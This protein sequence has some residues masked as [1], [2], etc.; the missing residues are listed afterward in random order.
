MSQTQPLPEGNIQRWTAKRKAAVVLDL[1]KGKI[2]AADAA[3]QHGLTVAELEQWK[4]DF[5][6]QGTEALRTHPR[7]RE[8]QWE[9][10]KQRLQA[11]VGEL[12]LEVDI[13]KKA[14]RI[15]GKDLP[16]GIS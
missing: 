1:I 5:L 12:A 8:A 10:E 14:H 4:D 13:L 7:D 11:K 16:E 3:R 6:S 2:T 9:A 15:L